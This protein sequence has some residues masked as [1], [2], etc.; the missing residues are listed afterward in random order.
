MIIE[1][2]WKDKSELARQEVKE[3]GRGTSMCRSPEAVRIWASRKN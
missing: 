2:N 1:L 3:N